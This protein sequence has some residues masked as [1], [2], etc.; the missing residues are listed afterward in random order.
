M[1]FSLDNRVRRAVFFVVVLFISAALF[2]FAAERWW[3]AHLARTS[4]PDD[5][6]KAAEMEPSNAENWHRLGRFRQFDFERADLQQAISYYERATQLDPRSPWYWMDLAATYEMIGRTAQAEAA[7]ERAKHAYPISA[8]V[9]WHFG[10]FLIRRGDLTRGFAEI[11]RAV[12][13]DKNLTYPAVSVCWRAS[14]D[15]NRLLD[16]VLPAT[17]AAYSSA[18]NFL[19]EQKEVGAALVVWRRWVALNDAFEL[20]PA[21][22]LIELLLRDQRW[23]DAKT[24]WQK[25][26]QAAGKVGESSTSG[27]L[28]WDGNFQQDFL[29]GGFGWRQQTITGATIGFEP[30]ATEARSRALRI[31]FDGTANLDFQHV[32]QLVLVEPGIRYRF[33]AR[34]RTSEISTDRGIQFLIRPRLSSDSQFFVTPV[35]VGTNDWTDQELEFTTGN[36]THLLEIMV[37]RSSS[38]KFDNKVSGTVWVTGVSLEPVARR[39]GV[40]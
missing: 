22:T 40:R 29:N 1:E 27:P 39:G 2:F 7:F 5:W 34:L 28:V 18:L 10:N 13:R 17:G 31:D 35:L 32:T 3:A 6:L 9:A 36:A 16:E 4:D 19:L 23:D 15:T 11:R 25:S 33:R 30:I 12:A 24:V 8:Q 37:F 21:F 26:L 38:R 20:R 14:G